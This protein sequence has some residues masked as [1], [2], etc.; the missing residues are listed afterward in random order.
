VVD[1][2]VTIKRA[3]ESSVIVTHGRRCSSFADD[4]QAHDSESTY[5]VKWLSATTTNG[6]AGGTVSVSI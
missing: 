3:S 6:A 4:T 2:R 5:K 1:Q